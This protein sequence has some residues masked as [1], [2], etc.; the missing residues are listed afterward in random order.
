ME[1]RLETT[2]VGESEAAE[3]A[4]PHGFDLMGGGRVGP[5]RLSWMLL[6]AC[7]IE[8]VAR[9]GLRVIL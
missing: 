6:L 7:K 3:H 1:L 2:G 8:H 4:C 9:P 5:S